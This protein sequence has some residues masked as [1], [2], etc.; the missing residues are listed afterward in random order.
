MKIWFINHYAVPPQYYPLARPSLFAKHLIDMG[1]EVTIFA[2]STVHNSDKNLIVGNESYRTEI[3]D[4]IPYVYIKCTDYRGNGIKRVINIVEFAAKLPVICDK[5]EKPDAIMAT[6]FDPLSCYQGIRY[7]KHNH[8]KAIAEIADLWPEK[9]IA[10]DYASA[11][12][13][14]VKVL[15]YIEKRIYTLSDAIIFT[16][17]GGYDYIVEQGWQNSISKS[18]VHYINNGID[19]ELFDYNKEHF[20]VQDDDLDNQQF[21]KVVYTGSV[22]SVNN[23]G[24]LL[25][26]AKLV[27]NWNIKFLVWGDG[28]ELPLLKDRIKK[29]KITN[30]VFKGRVEKKY[31]PYIT[32]KADLNIAH[33]SNSSLFRFGISFNKIFDYLASG[34]PVLCDFYA[35]YNPVLT[36]NAGVSV[37][38]G[39]VQD[40][41]VA[42][43]TMADSFNQKKL[44][45][46]GRNARNGAKEY[47]FKKLTQKLIDIFERI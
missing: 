13:P 2:A 32:S 9:L 1:H 5:F 7:A 10:Y 28:E 24:K 43:D 35:K 17:E 18:K 11:E 42:I 26:V 36:L 40:I 41:A 12:N 39:T 31:V 46:Y 37:N 14:I 47:D 30:V 29:E 45:E 33:N 38:S 34:K 6:V 20:M 44:T 19:L 22:R 25:D 21:F 8:V 3:V 4:G 27:K 23:L 16:F 15:R